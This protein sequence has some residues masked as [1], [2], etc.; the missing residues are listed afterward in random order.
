MKS[1]VYA[2]VAALILAAPMVLFAQ[3]NVNGPLT[4]AQVREELV[5]LEKVGYNPSLADPH[6]PDNIQAA[7]MRLQAQ[8]SAAQTSASVSGSGLIEQ[9]SGQNRQ[10]D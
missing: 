5:Q 7:Q 6:Y 8:K 9:G 4:R 10:V 1:A 2:A 3:Q